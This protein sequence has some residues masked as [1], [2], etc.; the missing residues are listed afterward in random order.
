M[1]QNKELKNRKDMAL[2]NI[3]SHETIKYRNITK[4]KVVIITD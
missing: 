3:T 4:T 2:K 1:N